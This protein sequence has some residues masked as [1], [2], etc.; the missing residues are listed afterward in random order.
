MLIQEESINFDTHDTVSPCFEFFAQYCALWGSLTPPLTIMRDLIPKL[1]DTL[2]VHTVAISCK[3]EKILA[4]G[5]RLAYI[6][7]APN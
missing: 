2:D 7:K 5:T 4:L 1:M 3:S 6:I